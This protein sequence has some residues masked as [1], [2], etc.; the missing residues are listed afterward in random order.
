MKLSSTGLGDAAAAA[1]ARRNADH[2]LGGSLLLAVDVDAD[3][4]RQHEAK[5]DHDA[6]THFFGSWRRLQGHRSDRLARF[7]PDLLADHA[8]LLLGRR[9]ARRPSTSGRRRLCRRGGGG[10]SA[11]VRAPERPHRP[12]QAPR[13]AGRRRREEQRPG[14]GGHGRA[15][16][17]GLTSSVS[18][19]LFGQNDCASFYARDSGAAR[20]TASSPWR[21]HWRPNEA[22]RCPA[23]RAHQPLRPI[24]GGDF[25]PPPRYVLERRAWP[26]P[27]DLNAS[28]RR[29]IVAAV[30]CDAR[31]ASCRKSPAEPPP[32]H[33]DDR[34]AGAAGR[35]RPSPLRQSRC[36]EGRLA[37][38]MASSAPSTASIR[39][40]SRAITAR[41]FSDAALGNL[42]F[43]SL[44]MRSADE[45]FTLYGFLAETV[46]T[47]PDRSWVEFTIDPQRPLLR[48][49]A[50]DARRRDLLARAPAR[51]GPRP[52]TAPTTRRSS[53]SRRS[54]SAASAS[55][56]RHA[57]D[58]ELPLI[59]GLMPILPKH[60]T[61]PD[62]FEKTT[63]KPPDRHRSL[64]R[65]RNQ[66]RRRGSSSTATPTTGRRTC[67]SSAAST[68]TT[69]SAS[70]ISA[71]SARMFEAFKK[72]LV[73]IY[74]EG[75]PAPLEHRLRFSRRRR[76][77]RRQGDLP[78][79][80][81][82]GHVRL[83]LQHPPPDLCR[84][85]RPHAPSPCCLDFDWVNT[86]PLLRRLSS[87]AG[88]YLRRF[89]ALRRSAD[90][91]T[92]ARSRCSRPIRLPSTPTVMD[93]TYRPRRRRHR[94]RPHGLP[95]RPVDSSRRP[96]AARRPA[97]GRRRPASHS[98]SRS[99]STPTR[100][101]ASPSPIQRT[102]TRL[103]IA[104]DDPHASTPRSTS[105]GARPT[106]ST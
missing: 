104:V 7:R 103:G 101:S 64:P 18:P 77:P 13:L 47:P 60:A 95:G 54:A 81:A 93:G 22:R 16:E 48:R 35:F 21:A 19:R 99:W 37:S 49:H 1:S 43:E 91:P 3:T 27:H 31:S 8:G 63:L 68:I 75:D 32:R 26:W 56:S 105:S 57:D 9:P 67:P 58:R 82:E 42:V 74:P 5:R 70:T 86:Q 73:D 66:R 94:R 33:G 87:A 97:P 80:I 71:T 25:Q 59:L 30:A 55:I 39:S 44:L 24:A 50:G 6:E 15:L 11:W 62:T 52:T 61:D 12:V 51:Q 90:R 84:H 96:A 100:T 23:D 36:P 92:T 88:G 2:I 17:S 46:E 72:G 14:C 78:A 76:R 45:P 34:R 38:P 20:V 79:G 28:L 98:P 4:R 83:R 40:S 65:H 89:R 85:P 41:G 102:L 29:T 10:P 69:R 106:T 53:A